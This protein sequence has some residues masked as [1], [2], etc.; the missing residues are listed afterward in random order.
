MH[1]NV[2]LDEPEFTYKF[3]LLGDKRDKKDRVT[4]T[5]AGT[6]VLHIALCELAKSKELRVQF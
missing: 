2:E 6:S 1:K 3:F 4:L 5:T